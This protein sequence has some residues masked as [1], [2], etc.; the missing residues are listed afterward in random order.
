MSSHLRRERQENFFLRFPNTYHHVH[1]PE[2]AHQKQ[3]HGPSPGILQMHLV[4][5]YCSRAMLCL[6]KYICRLLRFQPPTI[7]FFHEIL[8]Q[9]TAAK[10]N[11]VVR[12]YS[13]YFFFFCKVVS[14]K[15]LCLCNAYNRRLLIQILEK[16]N[17]NTRNRVR[18]KSP[19]PGW[20]LNQGLRAFKKWLAQERMAPSMLAGSVYLAEYP[21]PFRGRMWTLTLK[22]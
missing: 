7:L 20:I 2:G 1:S 15:L 17:R 19:K 13:T 8:I 21:I 16:K 22:C 4:K 11:C 5:P 14:R 12:S 3:G 9:D 10:K 18:Y 6:F